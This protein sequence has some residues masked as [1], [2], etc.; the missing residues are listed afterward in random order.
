MR[1]VTYNVHKCMGMDRREH[2]AR[3]A[4]VLRE[5]HADII[6]LQEVL[7]VEG[8]GR[9]RD[10]AR[11]LAEEL[12]MNYQVG[13][14][15]RLRGGI[16]GNV[17]LSRTPPLLVR[18]YDITWSGRERRGCL[19]TDFPMGAA[20][21]HVF[22]IHLG[23]AFME[24]RHQARRLVGEEI[25]N[26]AGL[27]GARVALGDFNEW[28]RGLASKLL[29]AHMK[30]AD[31]KYH[32][33]RARTYPGL[34]PFLHLDHVYYDSA[35]ELKRLTLHRTRTALVASDHLP[36]VADFEIKGTAG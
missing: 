31:V 4:E 7:S 18:N 13:E 32:L 19:R 21:I 24:R 29:S 14:T 8:L 3:V 35:L 12:G 36:L 33:R 22:N 15:R 9:E 23:T 17:T 25:L 30:S 6:A 5:T 34:F 10:Q 26:S 16:Y 27:A 1:I 11:F 28:T 2:P 20:T